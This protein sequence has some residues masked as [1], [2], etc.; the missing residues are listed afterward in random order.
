MASFLER[1]RAPLLRGPMGFGSETAGDSDELDQAVS[2]ANLRRM[3]W[4]NEGGGRGMRRGGGPQDDWIQRTAIQRRGLPA[5]VENVVYDQRPE[6]FNKELALKKDD[7]AVRRETNAVMNAIRQQNADSMAQRADAYDFGVRNPQ[8]Q[9]IQPR[10]G[11]A[12][13]VD[14]RT[15]QAKD[16][17][18]AMG[19]MT[20]KDKLV[21]QAENALNAIGARGDE[22]RETENTRQGGRVDLAKMAAEARLAAIAAQSAGASARQ[23]DAQEFTAGR[24]R[25][26]SAALNQRA[27]DVSGISAEYAG[28]IQFDNRGNFTLNPNIDD[29]LRKR[30]TKEIYGERKTDI[31]LGKGSDSQ[32]VDSR[33]FNA[34]VGQVK[35]QRNAA[36]GEVRE[37]TDGGKTW[38]IVGR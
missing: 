19:T 20:E 10:G 16:T 1:L 25:E 14:R 8:G 4:P 22:A 37:S 18:V 11:N 31:N 6:Q 21:Q 15:G 13:V 34:G 27:R 26:H 33:A 29:D 9:V 24:P 32:P 3:T 35:R 5:G 12:V 28:A 2:L 17:G 30:I 36:T 38:K 23:E 7:L